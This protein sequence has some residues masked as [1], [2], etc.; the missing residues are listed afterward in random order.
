MTRITFGLYRRGVREPAV[1]LSS[2]I[3]EFIPRTPFPSALAAVT[4]YHREG[5]DAATNALDR[6]LSSS[7]YWGPGG[8]PQAQGWADAIRQSFDVYRQVADAD[9]RPPFA[10]GL[11]RTFDLPPDELAVYIDVVLIDPRGYVPRIVLWDTS[12]LNEERSALYAGPV[13]RVMEIELGDG[14]VPEVEV[15]HL[16]SGA[17]YVVD[18]ATAAA[19]LPDVARVVHRLGT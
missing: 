7:D 15:W 4:R 3:G 11:R 2:T 18:A 6:S 13:W 10:W 12:E 19:A 17:R 9:P 5:G 14:R 16:R 1:T 8:T